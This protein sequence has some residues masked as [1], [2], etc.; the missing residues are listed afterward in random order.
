MGLAAN[1][2]GYFLCGHCNVALAGFHACSPGPLGVTCAVPRPLP[3]CVPASS[4]GVRASFLWR[5]RAGC[6]TA[7]ASV[8]SQHAPGPQ[9]GQ[10][11][12]AD[13]ADP[14]PR[15]PP[16][17]LLF[18]RRLPGRGLLRPSDPASTRRWCYLLR[19]LPR[20]SAP[21][22]EGSA[23]NV[24]PRGASGRSPLC[25]YVTFSPFP[26]D[27]GRHCPQTNHQAAV[28][29]TPPRQKGG[30]KDPGWRH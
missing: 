9:R 15:P 25:R 17:A 2:C 29:P 7:S 13:S 22:S 3:A 4:S 11:V 27:R 1:D 21:P 28:R 8:S 18:G 14:G 16:R 6:T 26:P 10:L 30:K 19:A 5:V 23:E 12:P 20:G 24:R